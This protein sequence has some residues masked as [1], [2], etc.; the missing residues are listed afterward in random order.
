MESGRKSRLRVLQGYD[1]PAEGRGFAALML[2]V[3]ITGRLTESL[4]DVAKPH[5]LSAAQFEVLLCLSHGEGISQQELADRLLVTKG[6]ICVAVQKM[7]AAELLERR[8]DAVDQR[9]Q[10]LYLTAAAR[11]VL[12]KGKPTL[13][14]RFSA[15]LKALTLPEQ[16]TLH[17]LLRRLDA[18]GEDGA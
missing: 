6:N 5:G 3:R 15:L 4:G 18:A 11:R 12:A 14:A 2:L 8:T 13:D 1:I 16:K 17:D 9:V 7:E 10:R